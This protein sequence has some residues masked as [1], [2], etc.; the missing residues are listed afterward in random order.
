MIGRPAPAPRIT[1]PRGGL[2]LNPAL[3]EWMQGFPPGWFTAVPGV[4]VNDALR[5]A[6]NSVNPMQATAAL[7][8]CLA[9]LADTTPDREA[10]A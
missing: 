8:W 5:L 7:H 1:G 10:T 2:K 9:V 6:G 3:G 4:G